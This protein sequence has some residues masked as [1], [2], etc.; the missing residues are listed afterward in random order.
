MLNN[1]AF[2][3]LLSN[4]EVGEREKGNREKTRFDLNQVKTWDQQN[5]AKLKKKGKDVGK[6]PGRKGGDGDDESNVPGMA[7]RDRALERRSDI[8]NTDIDT[9]LEEVVSKLDAEQTKLLGGDEKHTHLVR[10]LDYMLLQKMR[11]QEKGLDNKLIK[12]VNND[13]NYFNN[14]NNN[15]NNR[16]KIIPIETRIP[17]KDIITNSELGKKMKSY[18]VNKDMSK[19]IISK[20]HLFFERTKYDFDIDPGS[21]VNMPTTIT[22]S[23]QVS[24]INI[25]KYLDF[26][27]I[28]YLLYRTK[29]MI[30]NDIIIKLTIK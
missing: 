5:E 14:N 13:N 1:Q 28:I 23:L 4:G 30:I 21:L 15:N 12:D 6:T 2:K 20:P 11:Q 16:A 29:M 9:G 24:N 3:D 8:V 26:I 17:V 25:I 22:H 7:Y 10:G 18:L 19:S 27:H